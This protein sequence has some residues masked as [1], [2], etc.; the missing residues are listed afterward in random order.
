MKAFAI[1]VASAASLGLAA[2][3]LAGPKISPA[4]GRAYVSKF[5]ERIVAAYDTKL[6]STDQRRLVVGGAIMDRI[7]FTTMSNT[8]LSDSVESAGRSDRRKFAR[9]FTAYFLEQ[10]LQQFGDTSVVG[11][12]IDEADTMPDGDVVVTTSVALDDDDSLEIGW[13]VRNLNGRPRIVDVLISGFSV[14]THFGRLFERR[15]HGDIE[16]LIDYLRRT[17]SG[18][19][20]LALVK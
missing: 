6:A 13:R 5:G 10:M 15:S 14:A 20:M 18:S 3:A 2:G 7:D 19:R 9:L 16:R 4:E 12:A 1:A 17:V 11:F 8:V